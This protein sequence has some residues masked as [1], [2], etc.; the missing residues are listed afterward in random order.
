MLS[1]QISWLQLVVATAVVQ[2]CLEGALAAGLG[3]PASEGL[4]YWTEAFEL[5]TREIMTD[6]VGGGADGGGVVQMVLCRDKCVSGCKVYRLP[7]L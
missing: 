7:G 2:T 3:A 4:E 1:Y 5:P 6:I